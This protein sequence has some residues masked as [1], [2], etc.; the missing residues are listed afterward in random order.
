VPQKTPWIVIFHKHSPPISNIIPHP[1][2]PTSR[3][4]QNYKTRIMISRIS[5]FGSPGLLPA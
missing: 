1:L 5:P 4:S 3:L 2:G